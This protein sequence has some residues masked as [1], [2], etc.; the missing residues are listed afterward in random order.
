MECQWID[1]GWPAPTIAYICAKFSVM[2]KLFFVFLILPVLLV[3]CS[4]NNVTEDNS[5]KK[6]FDSANVSGSFGLFDNGQG[7]FTIYNLS[8]YRDSAYLPSSTFDIPLSLIGVQTGVIKDDS[9]QLRWDSAQVNTD[10]QCKP[11]LTL[12][13]AFQ[14]PCEAGFRELAKRIGRDTLKKWIDSL[15]Y[16]N[17]NISG[18]IDS[19]WQNNHLKVT[20]DEQLGMVKKLYFDQLPFYQRT[21]KIVR[22]IMLME[23]NANYRLSYKTGS[24]IRENG[25]NIDW[26]VGWVEENNH[27]YFFVLNLESTEPATAGGQERM[28]ILKGI[29]K[30]MGFFEGKK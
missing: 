7:N 16:G 17:K 13:Q 11:G 22:N 29:L 14:Y 12:K 28:K 20:S 4:Q 5:F 23:S 30:Q 10:P 19:F 2:P 26:T 15:G 24:G 27:L 3:G 6:Y 25:H 9:T 18:P 21:Q 8:R 1:R